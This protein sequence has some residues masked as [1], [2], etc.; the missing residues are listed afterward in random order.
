MLG[1]NKS[2]FG[3][4]LESIEGQFGQFEKKIKILH[5]SRYD[6]YTPLGARARG[7]TTCCFTHTFPKN[8]C[9]NDSSKKSKF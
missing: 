4:F 8:Q 3:V 6:F 1:T 7:G 9:S 5:T 2:G